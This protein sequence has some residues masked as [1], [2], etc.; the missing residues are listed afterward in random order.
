MGSTTGRFYV[1]TINPARNLLKE[2]LF[3]HTKRELMSL[4]LTHAP[5]EALVIL[6]VC[7]YR[8][9]DDQAFIRLR[10]NYGGR[11]NSEHEALLRRH[12]ILGLIQARKFKSAVQLLESWPGITDHSRMELELVDEVIDQIV[13]ASKAGLHVDL[14]AGRLK[15]PRLIRSEYLAEAERTCKD[16]DLYTGVNQDET[17]EL[18]VVMNDYLVLL[19]ELMHGPG[20]DR[21]QEKAR[22]K[23]LRNVDEGFRKSL[24]RLSHLVPFVPRL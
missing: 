8:L 24:P 22:R 16:L 18:I 14:K 20:R 13:L 5:T 21:R 6:A 9:G 4:D 19:I 15:A 23:A 11:L 12:E 1:P 7:D 17:T 10:R 2:G 3:T